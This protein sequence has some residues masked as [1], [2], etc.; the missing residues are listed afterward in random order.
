LI[1]YN[2][3]FFPSFLNMSLVALCAVPKKISL[4]VSSVLLLVLQG[5]IS[6]ADAQTWARSYGGSGDEFV[7]RGVV[8]GSDGGYLIAGLTN[9]SGAGKNDVWIIKLDDDGSIAWQ[10]TFGGVRNEE[11]RSVQATSDGGYVVAG[12]TN[13]FGA[14]ANDMWVLKL[15]AAG[16]IQWEKTYGGP[17]ADVAHAIQQ[18][19]D[20]GYIVAGFTMSFGAGSRD[21]FVVKLDSDGAVEWQRSYGGAKD[22]VIRFVKQVSDG[23]Y[24]VAGFTHSFGTSGDIMLIKLDPVGNVEWQK[25]YGGAA[26]E[27]VS[28]ILEVSGGYIVM[29]QSRSFS[30]STN[31]WVFK[32]D[33]DGNIIWQKTVGGGNFDELSAAQLTPDGGFIVAGETRSFGI[34]REDFWVLKFDSDGGV[35]WQMRYGGPLVDEAE[36]IALTDDGGSI[37]VGHTRSFGSGI[38]DIWSVKLDSNGGLGGCAPEVSVQPTTASVKNSNA[39][40][41]DLQVTET[42]TGATSKESNATVLD[43]FTTVGT[44][45][46]PS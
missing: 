37:V 11:P 46:P 19:S 12:P 38:R 43:T 36:S 40:P 16:D 42:N 14:G 4:V 18:T 10:K 27:E 1:E 29:E 35:E 28:T 6:A 34:V 8:A 44:Q 15:D 31:G 39:I 13:S 7:F 21:Y 17:K 3:A 23:G 32:I 24:I 41:V 30:K 9:S 5:G 22:D 45:C 26:F 33:T 20:G 2:T 25:R